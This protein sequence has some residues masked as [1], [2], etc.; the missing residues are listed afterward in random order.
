MVIFASVRIRLVAVR[1]YKNK[2]VKVY[3]VYQRQGGGRDHWH[4]T[5]DEH[6][7][8]PREKVSERELEQVAD[9]DVGVG[10]RGQ[11]APELGLADLTDVSQ[12]RRL[13]EPDA[14]AHDQRGT[15]QGVG[16]LRRV[17]Q[18]PAGQVQ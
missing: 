7:R 14:N 10:E 17:H 9:D 18:V 3:G 15:V 2:T 12:H 11:H 5:A 6:G 8:S 13:Q 1:R 16:G 4:R